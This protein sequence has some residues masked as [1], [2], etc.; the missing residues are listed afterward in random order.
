MMIKLPFTN[1]YHNFTLAP[2]KAKGRSH[3]RRLKGRLGATVGQVTNVK[4][5][6]PVP[7]D[8]IKAAA[9]LDGNQVTYNQAF[10]AIKDTTNKYYQHEKQS[11]QLIVPYL[12]RI[13]TLKS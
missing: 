8:V 13:M 11:F 9:T 4:D 3:K 2:D 5:A 10:R 1:A 7:K 12:Q 6:E